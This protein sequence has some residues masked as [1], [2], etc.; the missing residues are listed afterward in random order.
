[1]RPGVT[2]SS[3]AGDGKSGHGADL[4]QRPA[5]KAVFRFH[6]RHLPVEARAGFR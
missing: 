2:V 5:A 4:R 1:M 6:P 3:I